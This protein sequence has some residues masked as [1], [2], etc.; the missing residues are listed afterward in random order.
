[1]CGPGYLSGMVRAGPQ[2][3]VLGMTWRADDHEPLA[4]LPVPSSNMALDSALS[5]AKRS[6]SILRGRQATGSCTYVK[7]GAVAYLAMA[8][9]LFYQPQKPSSKLSGSV[10]PAMTITGDGWWCDG[11]WRR[12]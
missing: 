1:M 4:H 9:C 2:T 7:C 10:P 5:T 3:A 8:P 12:Q 11:A 6:V